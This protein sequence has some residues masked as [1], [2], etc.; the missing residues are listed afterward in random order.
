MAKWNILFFLIVSHS[1]IMAQLSEDTPL[2]I[3]PLRTDLIWTEGTNAQLIQYL[4]SK[5]KY[6]NED[7]IAGTIVLQVTI[8]TMGNV[9]TPIIRRSISPSIEEQLLCEIESINFIPATNRN[10][11]VKSYFNLPFR[12]DLE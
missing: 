12:I 7:C 1:V 4:I 3:T 6:P 8:D 10:K 5:I 9:T 11:S 2:F